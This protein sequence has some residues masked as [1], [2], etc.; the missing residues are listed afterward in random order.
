MCKYCDTKLDEQFP[1]L[2]VHGET[3]ARDSSAECEIAKIAENY[4]IRLWGYDVKLSTE[5]IKFC[6]FCGKKLN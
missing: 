5:P 6:P 3:I 4:Y 2:G 1:G